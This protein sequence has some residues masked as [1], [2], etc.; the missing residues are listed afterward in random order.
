[1]AAT[2]SDSGE[3]VSVAELS[4]SQ[5]VDALA[6]EDANRLQLLVVTPDEQGEFR[7]AGLPGGGGVLLMLATVRGET[8]PVWAFALFGEG[9]CPD[10]P[11]ES[12]LDAARRAGATVLTDQWIPGIRSVG[13]TETLWAA[14][15]AMQ[16]WETPWRHETDVPRVSA[17]PAFAS[18]VETWNRLMRLETEPD[19]TAVGTSAK[20]T[21][22]SSSEEASKEDK[23]AKLAPPI[24]MVYFAYI[25][26]LQQAGKLQD[27]AAYDWLAEHGL[28]ESTDYELATFETWS[29]YLRHARAALGEQKSTRRAGR[30]P[31]RSV[32]KASELQ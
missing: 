18:S 7:V 3:R 20:T 29:R 26:A 14:C 10:E 21:G 13:S 16:L 22:E 12:W 9:A 15:V 31:G 17:L 4:K 11:F 30:P 27:Q 19:L 8:G 25:Y 24:R 5:F 1:M 32:V 23:L 28:P 6:S 2:A